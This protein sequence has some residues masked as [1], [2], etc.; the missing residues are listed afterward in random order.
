[1]RKI[2]LAA[3]SLVLFSTLAVWAAPQARVG[4]PPPRVEAPTL[5]PSP[6]HVWVTGYWK[7]TGINYE[8]FDG[9]WVKAK[10]G[11]VWVAGAWEQVGSRWA[12]TPGKW[13][14]P[15]KPKPEA[16]KPKPGKQS[17]P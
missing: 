16:R 14:K 10:K 1:M 17:L 11:K 8:W 6:N 13:A 12:W 4:P 9:R 2:A 3:A 15:E 7:W 5:Q